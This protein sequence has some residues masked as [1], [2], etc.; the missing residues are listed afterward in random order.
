MIP[1]LSASRIAAVIGLNAY[2]PIHEVMYDLLLKE[3]GIR[4]RIL[5]IENTARRVAYGKLKGSLLKNND[6]RGILN[7]AL[8]IA[9]EDVDRAVEHADNAATTYVN[10]YYSQYPATVR[11]SLIAE[12]RGAVAKQRGTNEENAILNQ[13][14]VANDVVVTERNSRTF[15]KDYGTYKLVGR[16]D[17]FVASANRIVDSKN[18]MRWRPE[19]PV[20]DEI[21]LRAYMDLSGAV[22]SE[23][24]ENFP[25]RPPRV[26]KYLNDPEKWSAIHQGIVN[27]V[28]RMNDIVADENLLRDLVFANTVESK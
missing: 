1:E 28:T 8:D 23:L 6:I 26:T 16:T 4:S 12:V 18:R 9:K 25:D 17:G 7:A 3:P 19:V 5:L 15:R 20:Y 2:Q 22:E 27:A 21:Q 14:E 10:M 24:I 13:Y 11:T